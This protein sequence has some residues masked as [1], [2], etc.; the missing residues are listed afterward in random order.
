MTNKKLKRLVLLDS[1]AILHRAYHALPDFA[2]SKGVPTG[3]LY[4][5]C[6]ML[7]RI[8]DDFRPDYIVAAYD[9]PKPTYRHEVYKEYKAGRVKT[10]D[11]LI[12]QI[13]E[14]RKVFEAFGIP[15]YDCE[16]FEADDVLGTIVE[17]TK[18]DKELEI[19]IASGDMDTLQLVDDDRVRVFTLKKGIKD[20]ILYN[21]KGVRERFGFGPELLPDYKGLRGDPSDNI[22]GIKGIGEKTAT[23]LITSFGGIAG[24][25][26]ALAKDEEKFAEAG[27]TP[28]IVELLKNGKDDAEFSKMLGTIRKDAPIEF[29]LPKETFADNIDFGKLD[30]FFTELEFRTL[31]A[32]LRNILGR[33]GAPEEVAEEIIDEKS[34]DQQKLKEAKIMLWLVKSSITNP[35]LEDIFNHT[36]TKDFFTAYESLSAEIKE[37]NLVNVYEDIEKPLIPIVDGMKETGVKIDVSALKDLKREFDKEIKSLEQNIWKMSGVEFNIS[38]PKQLGEVLFTKMG[39]KAK[40]QKKTAS[41]GFSTK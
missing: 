4:G 31:G 36:K 7:L 28:R 8:I 33:E 35:T 14:S 39:L 26:K 20:T 19:I 5:L 21:E 40:Y 10:D 16:G 18:D 22:P 32:K 30:A 23:I 1:H 41:G 34:I 17:E 24:I 2:T 11:D 27:I 25:Y 6:L 15:I 3:A 12:S 29:S 13:K 38:S 37:K 9:L